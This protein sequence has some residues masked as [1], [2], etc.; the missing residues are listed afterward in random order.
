MIN[1]RMKDSQQSNAKDN[2]T[3]KTVMI[4]SDNEVV[5]FTKYLSSLLYNLLIARDKKQFYDKSCFFSGGK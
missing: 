2:K 4:F 3:L 1:L 5:K